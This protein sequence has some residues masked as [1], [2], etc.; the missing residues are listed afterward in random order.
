[1]PNSCGGHAGSFWLKRDIARERQLSY[2]RF[3]D[4]RGG[5]ATITGR[6]SGTNPGSDGFPGWARVSISVRT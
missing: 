5:T 6:R 3:F 4:S 2:E 1:M